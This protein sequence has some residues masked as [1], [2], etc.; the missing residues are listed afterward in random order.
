[1]ENTSRKQRLSTCITQHHTTPLRAALPV[2]GGAVQC[3]GASTTTSGPLPVP[4]HCQRC[5]GLPV[6][7]VPPQVLRRAR[8]CCGDVS[9]LMHRYSKIGK[10]PAS[11]PSHHP[12]NLTSA[13]ATTCATRSCEHWSCARGTWPWPSTWPMCCAASCRSSTP[14]IRTP[15]H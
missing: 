7:P 8:H 5:H 6:R 4:R 12:Q 2:T 9:I 13:A 14:P 11:Q 15:A 1:M 10:L 3:V